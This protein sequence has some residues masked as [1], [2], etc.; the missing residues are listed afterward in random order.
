MRCRDLYHILYINE[1][2]EELWHHDGRKGIFEATS[3]Q[4]YC[5]TVQYYCSTQ[6]E[7]SFIMG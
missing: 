7:F 3:L 5:F 1:Y 4:K 2:C 6:A